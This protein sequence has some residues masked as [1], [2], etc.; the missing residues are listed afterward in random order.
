MG[1]FDGP[2]LRSA[3]RVGGAGGAE[4][5]AAFVGLVPAPQPP[6][7]GPPAGSAPRGQPGCWAAG[8]QLQRP[9]SGH[10]VPA[11]NAPAEGHAPSRTTQGAEGL[12]GEQADDRVYARPALVVFLQTGA[13]LTFLIVAG[14]RHPHPTPIP[15]PGRQATP[16]SP[17]QSSHE[18]PARP[19]PR[20]AGGETTG[21]KAF[22]SLGCWSMRMPSYPSGGPPATS[23]AP[24]GGLP[25]N[26]T[27][28]PLIHGRGE[29]RG[30]RS[31][32]T[33]PW[34]GGT[35][36]LSLLGGGSGLSGDRGPRTT[37]G[38][39]ARPPRRSPH[40]RRLGKP[41]LSP[42]HPGQTHSSLRAVTADLQ[43]HLT[44]LE[45]ITLSPTQFSLGGCFSVSLAKQKNSNTCTN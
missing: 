44:G 6:G 26:F 27:C 43:T 7:L 15:P 23:P 29:P 14:P 17:T 20:M 41:P 31:T 28:V 12:R 21:E 16:A 9:E 42:P 25:R 22:A 4:K 2:A 36:W 18:S 39:P 40:A 30:P 45:H 34:A 3:G 11:C 10:P 24:G 33:A 1:P 19:P 32:G 8:A 35:G 13:W 37:R 5:G 38:S